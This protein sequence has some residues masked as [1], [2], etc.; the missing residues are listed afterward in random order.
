MSKIGTLVK[1]KKEQIRSM[2]ASVQSGR[3]SALARGIPEWA[4]IYVFRNNFIPRGKKELSKIGTCL[5]KRAHAADYC[6]H[7]LDGVSI[8]GD[9]DLFRIDVVDGRDAKRVHRMLINEGRDEA[10]TLTKEIARRERKEK[11]PAAAN[12]DSDEE[13]D[14][15]ITEEQ[16]DDLCFRMAASTSRSKKTTKKK[17]RSAERADPLSS[18]TTAVTSTSKEDDP[19]RKIKRHKADSSRKGNVN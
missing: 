12:G 17:K 3:E 19:P 10:E 5:R 18:A 8:L 9:D 14:D 13:E 1:P 11:L 16:Y 2:L 6:L 7:S 15:E 4:L